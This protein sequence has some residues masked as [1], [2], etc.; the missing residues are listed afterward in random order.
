MISWPLLSNAS[1]YNIYITDT[2]NNDYILRHSFT[3]TGTGRAEISIYDIINQ[4]DLKVYL[5]KIV[6]VNSQYEGNL[7]EAKVI[8]I[9]NI[10][11]NSVFYETATNLLH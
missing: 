8:T 7:A 6:G 9:A 3:Q 1:S 11:P 4:N 5:V 10:N 2:E